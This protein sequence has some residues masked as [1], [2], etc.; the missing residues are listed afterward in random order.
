MKNY[1]EPEFELFSIQIADV[2]MDSITEDRE[3]G[4]FQ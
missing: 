2:I 3:E 1:E 4:E